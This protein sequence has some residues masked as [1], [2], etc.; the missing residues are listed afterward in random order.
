MLWI[1]GKPGSVVNPVEMY[2]PVP[3]LF[4]EGVNLSESSLSCSTGF[5]TDP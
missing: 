4:K 3:L 1:A 5:T 2:Y